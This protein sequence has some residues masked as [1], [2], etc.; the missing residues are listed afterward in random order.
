M[1]TF[2]SCRGLHRY[3]RPVHV[4][5]YSSRP[6]F[7][8][9]EHVPQTQEDWCRRTDQAAR[10]NGLARGTDWTTVQLNS[11]GKER[12]PIRLSLHL[13]G[14]SRYAAV[15]QAKAAPSAATGQ[16][17]PRVVRLL[18]VDGAPAQTSV[19]LRH[20]LDS[21]WQIEDSA[22]WCLIGHVGQLVTSA[23][24]GETAA[25]QAAGA[26]RRERLA[27]EARLYTEQTRLQAG[28][29]PDAAEQEQVNRQNPSSTTANTLG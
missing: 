5:Q 12:H 17:D 28:L 11:R 15:L 20:W 23:S 13:F 2:S 8:S 6:I 22:L 7:N 24:A 14:R 3:N 9:D 21:W 18:E 19:Q 26:A 10:S 1:L 29:D 4:L 27:A 25:R 16:D